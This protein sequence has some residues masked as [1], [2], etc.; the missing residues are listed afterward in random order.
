MSIHQRVPSAPLNH[1]VA[2]LWYYVDLFPDHEREHVLPDGTFELMI[3]LEERPRKLFDRTNLSRHQTFRRGWMSGTHKEYLVIDALQGSTMI[4]AHFKPGG[5]TGLLG[6]PAAEL[7]GRVVEL[8]A[9]WG[10]D[11]WDWREQLFSTTGPQRKLALFEKLLTERLSQTN[12][13][14]PDNRRMKWAL[15]RLLQTP[16]LP[17]IRVLTQELGMSH[18]H[19]IEQFRRQ[20]GLTPKLF[21]RIRRFQQVLAHVQSGKNV[22][23]ADIACNCG[24]FDQA[25]FVND[26]VAFAGLNPSA[27]LRQHLEGDPNFVRA[28][29]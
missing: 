21:C 1:Y 12:S 23:W 2:W 24:Y 14:C 9:L 7:T 20:V 10:N 18:K 26:F 15:G 29:G 22:K 4:G 11:I 25:H 16:E 13:K 19:F 17:S 8:D 3:N 6:I 27:Y 5:A 28:N